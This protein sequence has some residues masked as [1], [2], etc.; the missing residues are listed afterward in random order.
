MRLSCVVRR[1]VGRIMTTSVKPPARMPACKF[2][3]CTNSSIPTSP[4]IMEGM[5]VRVSAANSMRLT[6]R[7]FSAYSVR[8]TAAPTPSG[9]TMTMATKMI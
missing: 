4:K 1:M 9:R 7:R 2:I 6:S 8:Y 3:F 5:P